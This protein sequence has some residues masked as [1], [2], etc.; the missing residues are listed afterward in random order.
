MILSRYRAHAAPLAAR[1]APRGKRAR[2]VFCMALSLPLPVALPA[3]VW[4]KPGHPDERRELLPASL[5]LSFCSGGE[6]SPDCV[7]GCGRGRRGLAARIVS[8]PSLTSMIRPA[9]AP[10]RRTRSMRIAFA[11]G[12]LPAR[13][14]L[15]RAWIGLEERVRA[16]IGESARPDAACAFQRH[17]SRLPVVSAPGATGRF[18]LAMQQWPG[19]V[20]TRGDWQSVIVEILHF[21]D[22]LPGLTRAWH[23]SLRSRVINADSRLPLGGRGNQG[24]PIVS[25]R[26]SSST[27]SWR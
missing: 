15:S 19:P 16:S 21:C 23:S 7:A 13:G 2:P 22:A 17:W 5:H 11:E 27:R 12:G 26:V 9:G 8:P 20:A 18:A 10:R 25:V 3:P 14:A 24:Q 1:E 4:R 6:G